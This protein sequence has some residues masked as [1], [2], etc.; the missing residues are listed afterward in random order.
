MQ[1]WKPWLV[2]STLVII[3]CEVRGEETNEP[4]KAALILPRGN[5][6]DGRLS[7]AGESKQWHKLTLTLH[8]PFAH[9]RDN[10][11]NPFTD[12]RMTVKFTHESGTPEYNVPGYF[13]ADGNAGNTSAQSGN[14]WRAH[15]SPDKP[16][17]WTYE[18]SFV[19]GDS[20]ATDSSAPG[21]AVAP[22]DGAKGTVTI[23]STDKSPPDFRA[24][25]RLTYVGE[26]YL[27][28][29]GSGEYF[30]KAGADSPETMLAY[31]DFDDTTSRKRNAPLKT[32]Q[33]HAADWREGDPTWKNEKGKGLIGALNYLASKGCNAFSFMPYNAGGDGNNVWPFVARDDKFHYDCSKLDQWGIVFDH[34]TANGLYLHFKLQENEIDDNRVGNQA[35]QRTVSESLDG[36]RLGP[37]RK[38]YCRELVARFAHALALNWNIGEENTQSTEE[39]KEMARYLHEIDP[40]DHHIV[41]HTFPGQQDQ[42][43]RPLLGSASFL[44]GASLQNGWSEAHRRTRQWVRESRRAG[45][46]WVCANDE[47]GPANLGVPPDPGY[48]GSDGYAKMDNGRRYNLHDI[49]KRTLWGTLLAGG[50]GVEYYFGYSLPQNDLVCEDF[51]SRDRSWDYCRIALEFFRNEKIPFWE[52]NSAD[53]LVGNGEGGNR[54]YCFAKRDEV[55]LVYLPD[56]GTSDLDLT[57]AAGT[58][59]VEWFNPRTGGKLMPGSISSITGGG[60]VALGLP[61]DSPQEDW[62]VVC[63]K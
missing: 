4:A 20:V 29:A 54:N 26:H 40:Y 60:Q 50:A 21:S 13:A 31:A 63:R 46:P 52:M 14:Q 10:S 32:W 7:V 39:I 38:L 19:R 2:L 48:E 49:R 30:L 51:R 36:G 34:A 27:R 41:V 44:T 58:F 47:Q 3:A 16:G 17:R 35:N 6:G 62:L 25:G 33:A 23:A 57:R 8:G 53:R 61:P 9:E 55:Y 42:V 12:Y 37:E 28:F 11:P 24:R 5:D 22:F 43:Y 1:F 56:G 45:R 18:V 15:F 59:R